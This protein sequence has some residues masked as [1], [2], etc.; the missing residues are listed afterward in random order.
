MGLLQFVLISYLRVCGLSYAD[1][2]RVEPLAPV[3][4][5]TEDRA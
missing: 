3:I 4:I 5:T 1:L 2:S